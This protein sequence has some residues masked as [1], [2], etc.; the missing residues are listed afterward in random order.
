MDPV[1]VM[2]LSGSASG[3]AIGISIV[4]IIIGLIGKKA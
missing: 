4:I 2:R 1:E 3:T